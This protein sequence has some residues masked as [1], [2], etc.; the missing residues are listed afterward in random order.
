MKEGV[1]VYEKQY[2]TQHKLI[3]FRRF[4]VKAKAAPKA[5]KPAKARKK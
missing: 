5:K 1:M 3:S 2:D 4:F